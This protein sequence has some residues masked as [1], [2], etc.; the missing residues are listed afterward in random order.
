MVGLLIASGGLAVAARAQVV[1][2]E[3]AF[4]EPGVFCADRVGNNCANGSKPWGLDAADI[5][6]TTAGSAP[7]DLPEVAVVTN[8]FPS[9]LNIHRNKGVSAWNP[10]PPNGGLELV[11]SIEMPDV[12]AFPY[13]PEFADMDGDSDLDI[14]VSASPNFVFVFYNQGNGSFS[15]TPSTTTT[16]TLTGAGT[17]QMSGAG[18]LTVKDLN[19]DGKLDVAVSGSSPYATTRST[20]AIAIVWGPSSGWAPGSISTTIDIIR[21]LDVLDV[22]G[23]TGTDVAAGWTCNE[24]IGG[25][26]LAM[27]VEGLFP[28]RTFFLR[29]AGNGPGG[30]WQYSL[31]NSVDSRS[32]KFIKLRTGTIKDVVLADIAGDEFL[33]HRAYILRNTFPDTATCGYELIGDDTSWP[34]TPRP[35]YKFGKTGADEFGLR[36][37]FGLDAGKIDLDTKNDMVIACQHGRSGTDLEHG[38]VAI[39][40]GKG[41]GN[42]HTE[43]PSFVSAPRLFLVEPAGASPKPRFVKIADMNDDGKNDL[44]TSNATGNISVLINNT[45]IAGG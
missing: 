11:T 43:D 20:A 41:N 29:N 22:T 18:G 19:A 1:I 36:D 42:F 23:G 6:G 35:Q 25:S 30:A 44:V 7:D 5:M 9:K 33:F 34:S 37:A 45:V 12:N 10:S 38:G 21:P 14:V 2:P 17:L 16:V 13:E 8:Q 15:N 3:L 4:K 27:S 28:P 31:S 32:L 26:D 40:Q 39:W 24:Q